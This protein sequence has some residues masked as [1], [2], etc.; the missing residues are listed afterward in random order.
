MFSQKLLLPAESCQFTQDLPRPDFWQLTDLSFDNFHKSWEYLNTEHKK[1]NQIMSRKNKQLILRVI[2][3]FNV[4]EFQIFKNT[5]VLTNSNIQAGT[6]DSRYYEQFKP[7]LYGMY[8]GDTHYQNHIPI[9]DYNCFINRMDVNRQSWF[10]Q[11]IKRNILNRGY[12]SFNMDVSRHVGL[13]QYSSDSTPF[14]V[15]EDQFIKHCTMFKNE[16]AIA[17]NIVPYRNFDINQNLNDIIMKSKFS[18]VLETY[19]H[20]NRVT[21]VSEKIFRCLKLPRPW[22]LFGV[23]HAVKY[24]R[25]LGFDVLDD[26]V[27]HSYDDIEFAIDRQNSILDQVP[28]LSKLEFTPALQERL[29]RAAVHNNALLTHFSA[30]FE[31]DAD[32]SFVTAV[33]KLN[34]LC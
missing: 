13:N 19:F 21:T 27:D 15:F 7:S 4:N 33:E 23:A 8:A 32:N 3:I 29:Q 31:T 34:Q 18:I 28:E 1:I 30:Y 10:Y 11:L 9:L 16:H 24:L 20:D 25:E 14:E 2:D 26:I 6:V 12:V 22:V 17:K 5:V